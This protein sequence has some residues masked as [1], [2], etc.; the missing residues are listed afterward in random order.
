[1]KKVSSENPD[2]GPPAKPLTGIAAALQQQL[3]KRRLDM[4]AD[5]GWSITSLLQRYRYFSDASDNES[6]HG[7]DSEWDD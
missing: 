2:G 6:N 7:N 5:S 3:E 1:L 4:H